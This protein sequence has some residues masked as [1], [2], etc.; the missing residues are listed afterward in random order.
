MHEVECPMSQTGNDMDQKN[1]LVIGCG[2]LGRW[3]IKGLETAAS[4]IYVDAV[5]TSQR[6]RQEL[7]HFVSQGIIDQSKI[8]THVWQDIEACST[9]SERSY[10]LV[11]VSTLATGRSDVVEKVCSRFD[12]E[13][14]LIE[15][16]LEQSSDAI[17]KIERAVF[18][19]SAYVNYTRRMSPWY[20]KI[21]NI[22]RDES[23]IHCKV[24]YPL[25]GLACNASHWIDLVNWWA[26]TLPV[27]VDTSALKNK[28]KKTKREGFWDIEGILEIKFENNNSLVIESFADSEVPYLIEVAG[29]KGHRCT[30]DEQNGRATFTDGQVIEGTILPQSQ[31]TGVL[32]DN[33][34]REEVRHLSTLETSA[35]C[36]KLLISELLAH[37]N[38]S[39]Y[40]GPISQ[41]PIT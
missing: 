31:L 26:N 37:W 15:K 21:S 8:S 9:K 16:P 22:L 38:L 24:T 30:I 10:D 13:N 12:F 6:S 25:L 7:E 32:L 2:N 18:G 5:D 34:C 33:L 40:R 41:L 20:Q 14:I 4:N 28:W 35:N 36:S 19:R 1:V 29:C 27:S 39:P 3:H 11:I 23:Q 17:D